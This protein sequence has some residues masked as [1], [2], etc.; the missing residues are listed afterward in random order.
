MEEI[1]QLLQAMV[2]SKAGAT[3]TVAQLNRDFK[4]YEGEEIPFRRF[5]F[6]QLDEMLRSMP[7]VLQL[8][9]HGSAATVLPVVTEKTQHIKAMIA[10]QKN[11][12]NNRKA[13]PLHAS[14]RQE[15]A[16]GKNCNANGDQKSYS[17]YNSVVKCNYTVDEVKQLVK[18]IVF[19]NPSTMTVTQLNNF[20]KQHEGVNIP[21]REFR[22][23][24]LDAMLRSFSDIVQVNGQGSS[25]RVLPV[26]AQLKS[27][28]TIVGK[29][30]SNS[31]NRQ[32][33]TSGFSKGPPRTTVTPNSNNSYGK[34]RTSYVA[35]NCGSNNSFMPS[36][37]N[38]YSM[39]S[40]DMASARGNFHPT[41]Y[42]QFVM[43]A[44]A[45]Y[46]QRYWY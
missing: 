29:I 40:G 15:T 27:Q 10:K 9:G 12:G 24:Q 25:A 14:Q 20:F 23:Q 16:F 26:R 4:T 42:E 13:R 31:V 33:Q 18:A 39:P 17:E 32:N 34:T 37:N 38:C 11:S 1:E 8:N 30:P 44:I 7:G 35:Q 36:A 2:I 5:G 45:N 43:D 6:Q 21:Y 19:S 41:A 46:A 28:N 3:M 22:F